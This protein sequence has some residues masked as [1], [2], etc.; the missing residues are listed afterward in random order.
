MYCIRFPAHW[1]FF[2]RNFEGMTFG[3]AT[4]AYIPS[5]TRGFIFLRRYSLQFKP[6][7]CFVGYHSDTI[8][9]VVVKNSNLENDEQV[10]YLH[11]F[12]YACYVL[13]CPR[14]ENENIKQ[15]YLF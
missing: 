2:L 5:L 7:D 11:M 6:G 12:H 1:N 3:F 10:F 15:Y 14:Y 13:T 9:A 4:C 8:A